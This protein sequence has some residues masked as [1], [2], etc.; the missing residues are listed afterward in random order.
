MKEVLKN[1]PELK[2]VLERNKAIKKL[3]NKKL[4]FTCIV[5]NRE[6]NWDITPPKNVPKNTYETSFTGELLEDKMPLYLK[7][8]RYCIAKALYEKG[9]DSEDSETV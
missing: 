4:Y 3:T 7:N 5:S 6:I 8:A 1:D 9:T 2:I